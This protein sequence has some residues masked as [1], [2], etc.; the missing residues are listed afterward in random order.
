MASERRRGRR[1]HSMGDTRAV[2]LSAARTVFAE[3]GLDGATL[4]DIARAAGVDPSLLLHYFGSKESLFFESV[5]D[6]IFPQMEQV[7]SR[8]SKPEAV[9]K[10]IV[11]TFLAFWDDP[12][13]QEALIALVRAGVSNE[14]VGEKLRQF[15]QIEIPARVRTRLQ[16]DQERLRVGLA[17]SQL[18]GLAIARYVVRLPAITEAPRS[19]IVSL[20]SPTL[21]RYL[22]APLGRPRAVDP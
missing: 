5:R 11:E 21:A 12:V 18:V 22:G 2:I 13:N 16:R 19:D 10:D 1:P 8:S 15:L 6:R 9:A 7:L 20:V 17:A 4:R 3:R 14:R